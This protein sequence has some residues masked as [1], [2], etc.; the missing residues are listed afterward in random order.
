[1]NILQR[2]ILRFARNGRFD[3]MS[4]KL[5][6]MMK[7]LNLKNPQTFNEKLQ[8]LKLYDRKPEYTMMVDKYRVRE[9]IAKT[10][11]EE[12]LIP[13]LGVWEDP[14]DIDFDA[15]PDQFVLKPNHASGNVVICRDKRNLCQKETRKLTKNWL[16]REY[17]WSSREWPY[18]NIKP[19]IIAEELIADQIVDYKFYCFNGEP[20][21]LYLSKGLE[22]H[23]T[24]SISFF[25]L[26]LKRLPFYRS[27]FRPFTD[28][29]EKPENFAQMIE[30]ARKLSEGIAFVRVDLYSVA[31]KIYFSELTFYPCSG[32][33]PFE[34]EEWDY[35]LGEWIEL[36]KI[37]KAIFQ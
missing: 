6:H 12:Y 4:D 7:W 20:K 36:P 25:D 26:E 8:W 32:Y 5:C 1:M 37:N 27:D 3:W 24:A 23:A 21:C 22:D 17:Y 2:A 35:K 34:P 33:M 18:K 9:Y 16:K 19:K 14:E 11:G 29:P 13:L 10:I 30:I 15:L 31:G 28:E